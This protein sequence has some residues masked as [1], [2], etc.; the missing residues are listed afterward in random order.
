VNSFKEF[1]KNQKNSIDSVT[2]AANKTGAELLFVSIPPKVCKADDFVLPGIKNFEYDIIDYR[3]N[4]F[5]NQ[6]YDILNLHE[7]IHEENLEHYS[8]FYRTDHHWN[9]DA[10]L[11]ASEKISEWLIQKGF[12]VDTSTFSKDNYDEIIMEDLFLGSQGKQVGKYFAGTDDFKY[13]VPSFETDYSVTINGENQKT[14]TGNF[15][16]TLF[17][18]EKL[19]KNHLHS[20]NYSAFLSGDFALTKIEN[21]LNENGPK[22]LIIKDSFTN[23]LSSYFAAECSS[24]HL[25]DPRHYKGSISDYINRNNFDAVIVS[26]S[27]R[28]PNNV[29]EWKE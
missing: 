8:L 27:A 5:K 28:I 9:A 22:V 26:L 7:K 13:Y 25:I 12:N 21:N 2:E 4:Y 19:T 29:F 24:L 3:V 20:F 23:V 11:W 16:V 1:N 18:K 14:Q 17:D 6:G 15:I 10:G